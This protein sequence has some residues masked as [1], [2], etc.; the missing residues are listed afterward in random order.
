MGR[1]LEGSDD[2]RDQQKLYQYGE[3]DYSP[4]VVYSKEGDYKRGT[5][6]AT[7]IA[8][9]WDRGKMKFRNKETYVACG[10]IPAT[11]YVEKI[12]R[13][14]QS[15]YMEDWPEL[16]K[17]YEAIESNGGLG[18]GAAEAVA[19]ALQDGENPLE[20]LRDHYEK[21]KEELEAV[22]I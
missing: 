16:Q 6:V 19:D 5:T 20:A 18:T 9:D 7:P 10:K 1:F 4:I 11:E 21:K 17:A 2:G 8:P 14:Y 22:E 12:A 3:S 13:Y 15:D